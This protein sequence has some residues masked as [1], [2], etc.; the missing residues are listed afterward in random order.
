MAETNGRNKFL[1]VNSKVICGPIV[2]FLLF[3]SINLS[4]SLLLGCFFRASFVTLA[5]LRCSYCILGG[6]CGT[7][8]IN[9]LGQWLPRLRKFNRVRDFWLQQ[10]HI[11]LF[12]G[13]NFNDLLFYNLFSNWVC[14]ITLLIWVYLFLP[15][16]KWTSIDLL[17]YCHVIFC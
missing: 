4:P 1:N 2:L 16:D 13:T 14:F 15:R 7:P 3:A 9:L 17:F 11:L 12:Q 10:Q 8:R 6:L 5:L